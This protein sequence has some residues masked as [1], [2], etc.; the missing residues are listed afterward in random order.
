M[1][2]CG[3]G[4]VQQVA[5]HKSLDNGFEAFL[6]SLC[7]LATPDRLKG[8]DATASPDDC[9]PNRGRVATQENDL[10]APVRC[11]EKP[12]IDGRPD[13]GIRWS[14]F[15]RRC[16]ASLDVLRVCVHPVLQAP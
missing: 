8:H 10:I 9:L 4:R 2:A 5:G 6:R 3:P 7:R 1:A 16:V 11:H 14:K 13:D 15:A 12:V